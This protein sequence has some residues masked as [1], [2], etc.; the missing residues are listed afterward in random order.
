MKRIVFVL[1]FATFFTSC[2]TEKTIYIADHLVSCDTDTTVQCMLVKENETDEWQKISDSIAGF[3]YEPGYTYQL[4]IKIEKSGKSD[5]KYTLLKVISKTATK[6]TP[7]QIRYSATSRGFG[8]SLT[9]KG[10][11]LTYNQMRPKVEKS[12]K[13]LDTNALNS[14]L[15]L[16]NKLDVSSIEK[17]TPPSTAHQYDGAPGAVFILRIG[18]KE[19]RTPTFDYGNPPEAL[20]ELIEKLEKLK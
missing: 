14:I 11:L 18:D 5:L 13:H 12:E 4:K 7:I 1:V 15:D 10:D 17:L 20:K 2:E 19:Y 16:V 6:K 9:L 3:T 8:S